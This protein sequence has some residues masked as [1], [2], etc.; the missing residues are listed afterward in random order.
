MARTIVIPV[1]LFEK[2]VGLVTALADGLSRLARGRSPFVSDSNF[3]RRVSV[4]RGCP[5][6]MNRMGRLTCSVCSC[7]VGLKA[8]LVESTCPD[9]RWYSGAW[10]EE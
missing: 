10:V 8:R 4:C 3:A 1:T 6:R 5:Y 9:D 2:T 7:D